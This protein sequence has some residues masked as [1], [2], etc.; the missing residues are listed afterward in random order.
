MVNKYTIGIYGWDNIVIY[1]TGC[2]FYPVCVHFD[3]T[4]YLLNYLYILYIVQ[5]VVRQMNNRTIAFLEPSV[6]GF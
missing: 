5:Y 4:N 6:S 2:K 3:P 1:A